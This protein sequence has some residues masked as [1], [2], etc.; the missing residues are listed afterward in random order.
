MKWLE[1]H[2]PKMMLAPSFIAVLVFVYGFI[3]WTAWVSL[4]RSKLLPKYEIK[5][6][7]QYER[8]F[9]SPRWDTALDNLFIFGALFIVNINLF[10]SVR[11]RAVGRKSIQ[12]KEV[13]ELPAKLSAGLRSLVV[14]Y[15][16]EEG[17]PVPAEWGGGETTSSSTTT[18]PET[19]DETVA[20]TTTPAEEG[21][22]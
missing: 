16:E 13:E 19:A 12:T 1:T 2:L 14:P 4:T 21:G 22:V 7:I 9:A 3:G 15:L 11:T 6:T 10:D 18:S 17:L 8:L 5:G 20:T